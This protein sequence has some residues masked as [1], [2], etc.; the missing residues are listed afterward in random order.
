MSEENPEPAEPGTEP[1]AAALAAADKPDAVKKALDSE[2]ALRRAAEKQLA[3]LAAAQKAAEDA[4]KTEAQKHAE[5]MEAL[6]AEIRNTRLDA[7]RERAARANNLSE[8]DL[9]FI[10]GS[11]PDEIEES[12]KLFADR[13]AAHAAAT[14]KDQRAATDPL[15][16]GAKPNTP[17][18]TREA[19]KDM[20][21]EQYAKQRDEV[22]KALAGG[23]K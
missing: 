15:D 5:R 13:V 21:P 6:E 22:H 11:S 8:E 20:T 9:R 19:L 4:T 12:A 7:A 18:L 2:R 3:D 16:R 17:S 23:V 10:S 14:Q 1:D